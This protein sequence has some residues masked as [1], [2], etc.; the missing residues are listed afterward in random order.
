M[1]FKEEPGYTLLTDLDTILIYGDVIVSD[2][3]PLIDSP[4]F[5]VGG[6][7]GVVRLGAAFFPWRT[8]RAVYRKA[9]L[10]DAIPIAKPAVAPIKD[11]SFYLPNLKHPAGWRP[12]ALTETVMRGDYWHYEMS[13]AR[14][15]N[16]S[17]GKNMKQYL[18]DNEDHKI[19]GWP[20]RKVFN[21]YVETR[22]LPRNPIFSMPLPLP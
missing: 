19:S 12:L 8:H 20:F 9:H 10:L 13:M 21:P 22:R 4:E 17:I 15:A 6:L 1:I 3:R 5:V 11:V 14:P 7:W 2:R 16:S 18:E